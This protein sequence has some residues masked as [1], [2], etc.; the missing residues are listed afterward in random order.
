M[1]YAAKACALGTVPL[2]TRKKSDP[3]EPVTHILCFDFTTQNSG[4]LNQMF[5]FI[6]QFGNS[7]LEPMF[8]GSLIRN[9]GGTS[10]R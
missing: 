8:P 10:R 2:R 9:I 5:S 7:P 1:I 4:M 6:V 3:V